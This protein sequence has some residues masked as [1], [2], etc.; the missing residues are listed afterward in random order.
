[1]RRRDDSE[2]LGAARGLGEYAARLRTQLFDG[3]SPERQ[4]QLRAAERRSRVFAAFNAVMAGTREGAHVTGLHFVAEEGKLIVYVD[5][6]SWTQELTMLRE[7]I[8]ARMDAA[9]EAPASIVFLTS[10]RPAA[11]ARKKPASSSTRPAPAAAPLTRDEDAALTAATEGV[12]DPKLR[13][14]LRKAM[15]ASLEWKKGAEDENAR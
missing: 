15:K 10:K 11:R 1:M 13:E 3:A 4:G 6:A 7:I 5:G 2:R 8:R 12:G 14:A 9:G